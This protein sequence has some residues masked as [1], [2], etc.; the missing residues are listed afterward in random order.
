MCYENFYFYNKMI[1]NLQDDN[2]II[3][4]TSAE[5]TPGIDMDKLIGIPHLFSRYC[6]TRDG[7]IVVPMGNMTLQADGRVTGYS[8]HNEGL[9]EPYAYGTV[10]ADKAFAF[11][12]AS[13]RF[14][15]SSSWQQTYCDMPIGYYCGEP[16]MPQKICLIPNTNTS[17]NEEI[18][19]LVASC[20]GFYE[21][22]IPKLV[23]ELLAE[24]IEPSRIKIVVNG[25]KENYDE[26]IEGIS[27]AFSTHNSWELSALYEAPLRWKFDYAML[28]HDTNE[29][30]PGFRRKVE[31]FNRHLNWDH[32][33]ASPMGRC[34]LGLYSFDYLLRTNSF[35]EQIDGI[36]KKGGIKLEVAGE[37]IHRAKTVLVMSDP[38]SNGAARQ[39]ESREVADFFN[40]GTMR[41]RR[42]FPA[43]NLHKFT[44]VDLHNAAT[45]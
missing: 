26:M 5:L 38:E 7:F 28:I 31:S 2:Y 13:N 25:C 14:I 23:K 44:H 16:E 12:G 19:Y 39:G 45:L 21:K 11:V 37:L 1:T 20:I 33:P 3:Q 41:V 36:S 22:T 4:S 17:G 34:L 15:P 9:W 18:I 30:Y 10:D 6:D 43:I 35:L 40:Q 24:G 27:Y 32:L 42:V 8:H 29:I